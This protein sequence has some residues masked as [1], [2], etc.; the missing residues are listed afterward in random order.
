MSL[1]CAVIAIVCV[2]AIGAQD[3]VDWVAESR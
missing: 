2:I 1:R 3:F